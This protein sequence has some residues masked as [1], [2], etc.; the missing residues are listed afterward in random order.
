MAASIEWLSLALPSN[1]TR[2]DAGMPRR[3]HQPE[4]FHFLVK[5]R[6]IDAQGIGRGV[7][8]PIVE[9]EDVHDDRPLRRFHGIFQWRTGGG[10]RMRGLA[11]G[12]LHRQLLDANLRSSA[13]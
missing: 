7:A 8:I 12:Q 1:P 4:A 9:L 10:Q 3:F 11:G 13:E 6:A 5:R 2:S